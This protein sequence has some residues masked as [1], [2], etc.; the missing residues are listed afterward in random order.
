MVEA[1]IAVVVP[2]YNRRDELRRALSSIA[3]QT[4]EDFQVVV[5][6]DCSTM[7][8]RSIVGEFDNRFSYIRNS[9]NMGPSGARLSAYPH[10]TAPITTFLDSDNVFV[11][12]TLSEIAT[13]LAQNPRVSGVSGLYRFSD[14]FR[15]RVRQ[16]SSTLK[17]AEYV[18][19]R[20]SK[21]DMVGAVRSEVL[22]E[23]L[24]KDSRYF[25]ADFHTWLTYH[26]QHDHLLVDRHWG[27]FLEDAGER[28]SKGVDPR[29]IRDID[30]F[31]DE[32]RPLFG[33]SPHKPLDRHL[34]VF[35]SWSR[36]RHRDENEALRSWLTERRISD[37][38]MASARITQKVRRRLLGSRIE[39]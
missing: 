11:E 2:V 3:T 7:D 19:G 39:I 35:A 13:S 37:M 1:R 28:V 31:V 32:H 18:A 4:L 5:V 33:R 23:W 12:S 24:R 8:V 6:D 22:Q 17:P 20:E 27:D 9:V 26:S 25:M 10:V 36:S 29:K 38:G 34:A 16:Q 15:V 30:I 21:C 14:G